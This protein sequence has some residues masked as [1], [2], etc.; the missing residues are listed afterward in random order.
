MMKLHLLVALL[1]VTTALSEKTRR[2]Y[3]QVEE[4]D[5]D[6]SPSGVNNLDDKPIEDGDAG[7]S[8][9]L[10]C[11]SCN[12][13]ALQFAYHRNNLSEII[14]HHRRVRHYRARAQNRSHLQESP[15]R[16]VH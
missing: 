13:H 16:R 11:T 5:W 7:R 1:C 8:C 10:G 12:A 4:Q 2:Y 6:Y 3:V 9:T 14:F 15:L